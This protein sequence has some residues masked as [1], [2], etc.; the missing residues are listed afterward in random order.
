MTRLKAP[1][2]YHGGK[3]R[4][5]GWVAGLL[6]DS[7]SYGEPFGG[8]AAVML[9]RPPAREEVLNDLDGNVYAFWHTI[10][11]DS[12][13]L[14]DR[15]ASTPLW[16][17]DHHRLAN[18]WLSDPAIDRRER[19]Y[20]WMVAVQGGFGGTVG[21]SFA[22]PI[23]G[24]TPGQLHRRSGWIDPARYANRLRTVRLLNRDA[25][26]LLER[27]LLFSRPGGLLRSALPALQHLVAVPGQHRFRPDGCGVDRPGRGGEDCSV[28]LPG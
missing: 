9:A 24:R 1:M 26:P 23:A 7:M 15:L 19:A 3:Q 14:K 16:S 11:F 2:R 5:A 28:W 13:W 25:V 22:P 21:R 4:L 27:L 10:Q 17:E 8:M 12:E 6:P 18:D 20:W